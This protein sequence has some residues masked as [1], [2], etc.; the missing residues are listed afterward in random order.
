M[1]KEIDHKVWNETFTPEQQSQATEWLESG[2]L[3]FF[4]ELQFNI[5]PP[6]QKFLEKNTLSSKAKNISYDINKDLIKGVD[7]EGSEKSELKIMM[8]RF[9]LQA[10]HLMRNLFPS[11][12]DDLEVARTSFRPTEIKGRL[13]SYRKDDTRLH[14][15]AFPSRPNFGKRIIRFFSNVN[16]NNQ[17]RVWRV[18]EHFKALATKF[19]PEIGLPL[20]GSRELLN[21]LHI[22]KGKRSLY[23]HYMLKM[24]H[25]MK[26]DMGYQN[27]VTQQIIELPPNSSWIV[28]TDSVSHA[29]LSGQYTL[30]QTFHIPVSAMQDEALAP[31]R[32]LENLVGRELS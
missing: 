17:N 31:L 18:G 32:V 27:S 20:V 2:N 13:S 30:E 16:P 1:L 29:A 14:V 26:K 23:D 15:D 22:T 28:F 3:I 21:L 24:H 8:K 12:V 6:E 10:T 7:L 19:I 4:P 25:K 5:D 11:Y 9:S